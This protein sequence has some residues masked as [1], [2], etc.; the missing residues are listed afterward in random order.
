[1]V[2]VGEFEWKLDR[3]T[4]FSREDFSKRRGARKRKG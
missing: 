1:M 2:V 3:K 4:S